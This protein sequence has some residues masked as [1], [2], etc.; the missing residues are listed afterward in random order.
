MRRLSLILIAIV[1]A[2]ILY[3]L[4]MRKNA[5]PDV[6]F[7]KAARET[8][9]SALTTNGKV[10]PLL[11]AAARAEVAGAV[12]RT[13]VQRGQQVKKGA[14]LVQLDTATLNSDL[15]AAQ[16]RVAAAQAELQTLQQGG[17]SAEVAS[18]NGSLDAARQELTEAQR[19][20]ETTERLKA[21]NAATGQEVTA[22]RDRVERARLQIQ[23]LQQRKTAQVSQP[24]L[25]AADARLREAQAAVTAARER[26]GMTS[27]RAP[28]GG[29]VYQ[30]DL[31]SGSFVNP[32]D[33][34]ANIGQLQTVR[35][36]VY[37]DEPDLGRVEPGMPA[38]ITWDAMPGRVWTGAV[39]RKASQVV[40]LGTRQV[41]E[42]SCVIENPDLNL[43]PGTNVNVE[44]RSKVVKNA[45]TIPN[46]ALRREGGRTGVFVLNARRIQWHDVQLGVASVVRS[47]VL[48]GVNEGDSV[49]LP[50]D[51]N[52]KD[53]MAVTPVYP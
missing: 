43:L 41:G 35:I 39:E 32:G 29:T 51:R 28:I 3:F 25:S 20:F 46:A 47:Q 18:I 27:V 1:A 26:I 23:S 45:V 14:P 5:P 2:A 34:V 49:A 38:T 33:L 37:V 31:R 11:W 8:I 24:D 36:I 21:K 12:E 19:E 13:Y 40:A 4:V 10:E 9:V 42:V 44:I 15:A 50:T 30:F 22:A 16:A 6:P 7:A 17:R 53:G 52:L 48:S